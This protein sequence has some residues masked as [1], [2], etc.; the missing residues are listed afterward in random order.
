MT[1]IID[2]VQEGILRNCPAPA[3]LNLFLHV[4]GQ[5]PDGYHLLESAFQL[6][7]LADRL[8]FTLR[9]DHVIT[10]TNQVTG[11]PSQSDLVIR[12]ATLLQQHTGT[13][14]GAD[15]TLEKY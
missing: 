15:I 2:L 13:E 3:K 12:A 1:G 9:T 10:R 6:I 5:R 11:I 7:D 8:H 4:I 14:F